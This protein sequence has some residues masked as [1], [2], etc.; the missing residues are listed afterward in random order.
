MSAQRSIN[1]P[2]LA[3]ETLEPRRVLATLVVT[4]TADV[5]DPLDGDLSLREA[6][7][8]ANINGEDDVIELGAGTHAIE[9]AGFGEDLALAGDFD[10]LSDNDHSVTIRG[11]GSD[12]TF[13]DAAQLDRAFHLIGQS[14]LTLEDLT[15]ENGDIQEREVWT[16]RRGG[17]IKSRQSALTLNDV[18]VRDSTAGESGTGGAIW[19]SGGSYSINRSS[20]LSNSALLDGAAVF[21]RNATGSIF[22]SVIEDNA[23]HDMDPNSQWENAGVVSIQGGSLDIRRTRIDYNNFGTCISV[24]DGSLN[25]VHNRFLELD[26]PIS[27]PSPDNFSHGVLAR[28]SNVVI[29]DSRFTLMKGDAIRFFDSEHDLTVTNS[30]FTFNNGSS[31]RFGGRDLTI[32][33]TEIQQ[34][35]FVRYDNT[36]PVITAIPDQ[37]N[38]RLIQMTNVS[39]NRAVPDAL[40][41]DGPNSPTEVIIDQLAINLPEESTFFTNDMVKIVADDVSITGLTVLPGLFDQ[42]DVS[43]VIAANN[44]L[45]DGAT[46]SGSFL[47]PALQIEAASA[48]LRN[49]TISDNWSGVVV[50]GSNS[51]MKVIGSEFHNN[52]AEGGPSTANGGTGFAWQVTDGQ[53][54]V[55]DSVFTKNKADNELP[56]GHALSIQASGNNV[57]VASSTFA[58]QDDSI[59]EGSGIGI[60]GSD[61]LV[62]VANSL[63]HDNQGAAIY[64]EAA[65]TRVEVYNT[66]FARNGFNGGAVN[67]KSG[68]G[69]DLFMTN[70]IMIGNG[71]SPTDEVYSI[72]NDGG[73]TL[74]TFTNIWDLE[75]EDGNV[76]F[77]GAANG[78]TDFAPLFVNYFGNDFRLQDTSPLIDIG[79][80]ANVLL[81]DMDLDGDGNTTEPLPDRDLLD[82]I[83][84]A[85][86][87]MGAYENQPL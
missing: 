24:F 64:S 51:V 25:M 42:W 49:S 66:T 70:S 4:T 44:L 13:I 39:I 37:P 58:N 18:V 76:L 69:L 11:T 41:I 29:D 84:G 46:L 8:T 32:S 55:I 3:L 56:P 71:F 85:T 10:I 54:T 72:F 15:V 82:R 81:D 22:L 40:V 48:E 75:P 31:I 45:I 30:V 53:L 65:N 28:S 36:R 57:L 52:Q 63:F 19:V 9:M 17:A 62:Q 50:T 61:H 1:T 12:M 78:N 38:T 5:I 27:I 47:Q 83:V 26:Q 14:S 68:T 73:T 43:V 87:D 79:N 67:G 35:G 60:S 59:R 33:D 23:L 16:G 2:V 77:G 7:I 6:I 80:Q 74:V 20:V 21:A 34:G 86:V